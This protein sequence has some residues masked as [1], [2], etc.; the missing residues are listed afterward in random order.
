[1]VLGMLGAQCCF[2]N[3]PLGSPVEDVLEVRWVESREASQEGLA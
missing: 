1:M 2:L 3:G